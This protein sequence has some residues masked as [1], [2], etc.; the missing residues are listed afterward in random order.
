MSS[1]DIQASQGFELGYHLISWDLAGHPYTE[2][3]PVLANL[4]LHHVESLLGNSLSIDPARRY[5]PLPGAGVPPA[6]TDTD[7]FS[8]VAMLGRAADYGLNLSSL[9]VNA[10]YVDDSLWRRELDVF[11]AALWILKGLGGR[12]LVC[13]G[14]PPERLLDHDDAMYRKFSAALNEVG[15]RAAAAGL[16]VTYHPHL[17]FFLESAEQIDNA[18]EYLDTAVVGLCLDPAHLFAS[19]SDPKAVLLRHAAHVRHVHLKDFRGEPSSLAG[20]SR[21]EAFSVLGEGNIDLKGFVDTLIGQA[22]TGLVVIE[23]DLSAAPGEDC[24]KNVTYATERLGLTVSLS[25]NP[26][27]DR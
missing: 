25:T 5:M 3:Y 20:W 7:A 6:F 19:G 27:E 2:A 23:L 18:L 21:Y 17:D 16:D 24:T 12:M 11:E 10:T 9:F 22:Y 13:G 4:G 26:R 1:A 8:R 15:T 14:G